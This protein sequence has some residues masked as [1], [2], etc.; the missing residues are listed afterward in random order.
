ML[1][2][3]WVSRDGIVENV[4]VDCIGWGF[5]EK[6]SVPIGEIVELWRPAPGEVATAD[7]AVT[8]WLE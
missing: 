1:D 7:F 8:V 2:V 6:V 5:T 3:F 4:N